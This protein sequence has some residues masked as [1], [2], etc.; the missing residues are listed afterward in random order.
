[1]TPES[2][3]MRAR[4]TGSG[5]Q[6]QDDETISTV[7]RKSSPASSTCGRRSSTAVSN[8][9]TPFYPDHRH[10]GGHAFSSLAAGQVEE[11]F[12]ARL[13]TR[14][15]CL[16]VDAEREHREVEL[17]RHPSQHPLGYDLGHAGERK[18][19]HHRVEAPPREHGGRPHRLQ[20]VTAHLV[21]EVRLR[22]P[23]DGVLRVPEDRV[24][25]A[26]V[27]CVRYV[28]A[29]LDDHAALAEPAVDVEVEERLEHHEYLPDQADG[30]M[31]ALAVEPHQAEA[32]LRLRARPLDL[33]PRECRAHD[34]ACLIEGRVHRAFLGLEPSESH[35]PF[36]QRVEYDHLGH[37]VG[38]LASEPGK[39]HPRRGN[40]GPD[41]SIEGGKGHRRRV[42]H[43]HLELIAFALEYPALDL[44]VVAEPARA[45]TAAHDQRVH[46]RVEHRDE[47]A[48]NGL[49]RQACELRGKRCTGLHGLL[50]ERRRLH[51]VEIK[52]VRQVSNDERQVAHA[53]YGYLHGA[54]NPVR[55]LVRA[56]CR[57]M[58]T[59]AS[60]LVTRPASAACSS[61]VMVM[62]GT[63]PSRRSWSSSSAPTIEPGPHAKDV[64]KRMPET[65][66]VRLQCRTA[67]A[68]LLSKPKNT[69][70]GRL[71]ACRS[72]SAGSTSSTV[73]GR[74]P[75]ALRR[76]SRPSDTRSSWTL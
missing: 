69:F 30:E 63:D 40:N 3:L 49:Q 45:V 60:S 19:V 74:A 14:L 43:V 42:E 27:D 57:S 23:G 72:T 18:E 12:Q 38:E 28:D 71:S 2:T 56:A 48:Q 6:A 55:F 50:C 13:H 17:R 7:S 24:A 22:R 70:L 33:A 37:H 4:A 31:L 32:L 52:T 26:R 62:M 15:P 25:P 51:E 46:S 5:F 10:A 44:A 66:P 34:L 67:P 65:A 54:T 29:P 20:P 58:S 1:M 41:P 75:I 61:S 9:P 64:T 73:T 53:R 39:R 36:L 8:L 11:R 59:N 16:F 68:S 21:R 47:A 35:G 76:S